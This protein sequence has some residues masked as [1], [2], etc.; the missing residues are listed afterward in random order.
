MFPTATVSG[1]AG[2][3]HCAAWL[4]FSW[5][6][7][8]RESEGRKADDMGTDKGRLAGG[9]QGDKK[10]GVKIWRHSGKGN[11]VGIL[12]DPPVV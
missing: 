11:S 3:L 10:A 2:H 6:K 7:A 5:G 1:L 8:A 12:A 4:E 9:W